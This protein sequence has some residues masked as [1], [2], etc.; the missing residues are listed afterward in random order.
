M[1]GF[2]D[3]AV[4]LHIAAVDFSAVLIEESLHGKAAFQ[5]ILAERVN[6]FLQLCFECRA[7]QLLRSSRP[8]G[9]PEL[10]AAFA[11][12]HADMAD[13]AQPLVLGRVLGKK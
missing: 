8:P 6:N 3:V 4:V 2:Y 5:N 11:E 12:V 7:V 9:M 1:F 10:V 13:G